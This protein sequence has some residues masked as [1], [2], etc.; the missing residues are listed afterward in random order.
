VDSSASIIALL[1][2]F[3]QVSRNPT[4]RILRAEKALHNKRGFAGW[5]LNK[6]I[7]GVFSGAKD[8]ATDMG[9]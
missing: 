2:E 3:V 5:S 1:K 8:R 9:S 4:K 7:G 6:A